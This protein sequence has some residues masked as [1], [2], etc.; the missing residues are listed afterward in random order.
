MRPRIYLAGPI[1]GCTDVQA[2]NWRADFSARLRA[3]DMIGVSPLR[4]EPL[5]GERY[6]MGYACP[7]FG[8]PAVIQ[9]K[10]LTDVRRCDA[11]VAYLP[12]ALAEEVGHPSVGTIC[13]LQWA[14]MEDKMRILI[15]DLDYVRNNPVI[16]A[17]TPWR[18]GEADGFDRALEVLTGILDVYGY[19][20]GTK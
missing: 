18:F 6:G 3:H 20:G 13:E 4:C 11:T 9:A 14:Y 7:M 8:Q 19:N 2:N 12:A 16:A 5:V 10:N 15:T 1:A 17:T